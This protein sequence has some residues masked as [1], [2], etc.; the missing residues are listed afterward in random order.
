MTAKK[1]LLT[2]IWIIILPLNCGAK[3][4]DYKFEEEFQ[5]DLASVIEKFKKL[6]EEGKYLEAF[7]IIEEKE[8][9]FSNLIQSN[10]DNYFKAFPS[11]FS[12]CSDYVNFLKKTPQKGTIISTLQEEK[13]L[14]NFV[15]VPAA[16]GAV[17]VRLEFLHKNCDRSVSCQKE[18]ISRHFKKVQDTEIC[19]STEYFSKILGYC[20]AEYT[21]SL[22]ILIVRLKPIF[23]KYSSKELNGIK[24]E[25]RNFI[26]RNL[27][28]DLKY[29]KGEKDRAHIKDLISQAKSLL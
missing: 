11:K 2:I 8:E 7:K 15:T 13:D 25:Y 21:T 23:D 17:E 4:P 22:E 20:E 28:R 16:C 18:I 29:H 1:L 26:L 9:S 14:I 10:S 3:A 27:E 6:K 24:E 19:I 12:S 5:G